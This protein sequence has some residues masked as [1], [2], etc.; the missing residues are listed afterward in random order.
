MPGAYPGKY[1]SLTHANPMDLQEAI[2]QLNQ[3]DRNH[4]AQAHEEADW[5][6]LEFLSS[7]GF[8]AVSDAFSKARDDV[9]FWYS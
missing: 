5:I 7:Q 8:G 6:L 4:P 9:G 2:S 1:T 3:L